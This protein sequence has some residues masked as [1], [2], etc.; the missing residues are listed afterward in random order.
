MPARRSGYGQP[1]IHT[2][3]VDEDKSLFVTA[4]YLFCAIMTM[5]TLA[6]VHVQITI[7]Q[8][9]SLVLSSRPPSQ[10]FQPFPILFL[11]LQAVEVGYQRVVYMY[12]IRFT[13]LAK[14]E[15]HVMCVCVV[16]QLWTAQPPL[17]EWIRRGQPAHTPP[18]RPPGAKGKEGTKAGKGQDETAENLKEEGRKGECVM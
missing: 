16:L 6:H 2:R 4:R 17:A 3:L 13:R 9:S 5:C 18:Q 15:L 7:G 10:P 14:A 12:P 11:H 1:N 8:A